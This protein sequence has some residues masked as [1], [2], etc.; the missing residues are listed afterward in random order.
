MSLCDSDTSCFTGEAPW[1]PDWPAFPQHRLSQYIPS[2]LQ[3]FYYES[4][5]T[6]GSQTSLQ[7][8][9]IWQ[10]WPPGSGSAQVSEYM[11]WRG[12]WDTLIACLLEF[13]LAFQIT[14]KLPLTT[15]IYSGLL[16]QDS[17]TRSQYVLAVVVPGEMVQIRPCPPSSLAIDFAP[18]HWR[19]KREILENILTCLPSWISGSDTWCDPS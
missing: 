1:P 3:G 19:N 15:F 6:R 5:G 17:W 10:H 13:P 14:N 18:F 9:G 11:D 2:H 4:H 16:I 8:P 7:E 12:S